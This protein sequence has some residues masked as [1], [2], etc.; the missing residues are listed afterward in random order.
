[1]YLH[2]QQVDCTLV[3]Q[4]ASS[5]SVPAEATHVELQAI[6]TADVNYTMDNTTDP[7]A[8]RGMIL[9]ATDP[10]K[11]FEIADFKRIKFCAEAGTASLHAHFIG[12]QT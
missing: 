12:R 3:V 2:Y 10:P 1:M 6:D 11:L 7:G 4:T 9:R 5:F 8:S